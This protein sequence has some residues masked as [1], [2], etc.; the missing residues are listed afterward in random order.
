MRVAGKE[1]GKLLV[2]AKIKRKNVVSN[3]DSGASAASARDRANCMMSSNATAL[4][5]SHVPYHKDSTV[6]KNRGCYVAA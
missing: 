4:P 2:A 3:L 5:N 6:D 1:V